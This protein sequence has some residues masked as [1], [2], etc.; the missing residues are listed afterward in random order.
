VTPKRTLIRGGRVLTMRAGDGERSL[1]LLIEGE[2]IA[3]VA[4][5]I[6]CEDAEVVDARDRI[7]LPGFVDTHRHVWQTQL[8]TV[9]T[10]WSLFHYFTQMRLVYSAFYTPDD[11]WLGNHVGALEALDAGITSIV[12][13]CHILHSPEHS[14][15]A[16][17]GLVDSG[18]RAVFCYGLFESPSY[19]KDARRSSLPVGWRREDARRVRRDL[20]PSDDGR[21]LFGFA[22]AEIDANPYETNVA[23][24]RMARELGARRVSCHVAMGA[25]DA[26]SRFVEKL[27]RDGRLGEDLLFVHGAALTD[28]E[29]ARLGDSGAA[30]SA[31]PETEMQMGMG[32][33]VAFRAR[34]AG[35]RSSLGIDIV[36]NY[37]GDMFSQMR[38]CLQAARALDAREYE[39]RE[40]APRNLRYTARDVLDLATRGGAE[41]AGLGAVCGTLEEGK[42]A[43]VVLLRTDAIHMTPAI[44]A[45]GAVVLN[46]N[47]SDV[48]QV[49]VAG[50]QVKKDG[51]L[52]GVDWPSLAMRVRESSRR[53]VEGFRSVPLANIEELA[54]K[55]MP[56][57]E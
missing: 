46:A 45:A 36:S 50:R 31:T 10:D 18:I 49:W 30:I 44:D 12:D 3:A 51:R 4:P 14:D 11:V 43:D 33:P 35:V 53:I 56:R 34:D 5:R 52:A 48:E 21:V 13:H 57:V 1:D 7:V 17:A 19:T 42:Q 32:F 54:L 28:D 47:S 25:Y 55:L 26:G 38:L 29:L 22:P 39:R 9:A 41:A 24:I 27:G 15:A 6:E 16:V 40:R 37:S 20:L 2:R 23:E 8:R